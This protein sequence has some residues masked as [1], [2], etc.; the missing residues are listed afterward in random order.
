LADMK[1]IR[2]RMR[3][4]R[5]RKRVN[6]GA[7][8]PWYYEATRHV[9]RVASGVDAGVDLEAYNLITLTNVYLVAACLYYDH[10]SPLISDGAFDALCVYLHDH[11][12]EMV[13]A[14]VYWV[15]TVIVLQNLAAGTC[16]GVEYPKGILD[17]VDQHLIGAGK[18]VRNVA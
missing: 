1:P 9:E 2:R 11:Y 17:M 3:P 10:D 8:T 12:D 13:D 4:I 15:G 14:G 7:L 6:P 18:M 16:V 5:K